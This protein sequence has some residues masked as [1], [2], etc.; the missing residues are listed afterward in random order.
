MYTDC[1]EAFSDPLD[2]SVFQGSVIS[3][4][5]YLTQ[6]THLQD[7]PCCFDLSPHFVVSG[8]STGQL[9]YYSVT[10]NRLLYEF[11]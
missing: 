8:T 10:D 1:L 3:D 9:M 7:S 6:D 4:E 2:M 5:L 11:R